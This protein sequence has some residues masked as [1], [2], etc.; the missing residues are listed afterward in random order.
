LIFG[1]IAA[2]VTAGRTMM[3]D[4]IQVRVKDFR[5]FS[6]ASFDMPPNGLIL[7]TGQNN[8]GK[9]AL[10]SALDVISGQQEQEAVRHAKAKGPAH[11]WGGCPGNGGISVTI[12]SEC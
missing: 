5:A 2:I 6:E 12:P 8:A 3:A 11:V 9:S 4:L 7:V 1:K 10:L